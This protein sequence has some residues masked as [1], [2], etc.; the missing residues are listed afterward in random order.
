MA[1]TFSMD[2]LVW[3]RE[4]QH[5]RISA[6][7]WHNRGRS[8]L[9]CRLS[10]MVGLRDPPW[11]CQAPRNDR[12]SII[13]A[14]CWTGIA[15]SGVMPPMGYWEIVGWQARCWRLVVG[16]CSAV[17]RHR[18]RRLHCRFWRTAERIS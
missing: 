8:V 6:A 15:D 4:C 2:R 12:I 5:G 17:K 18:W 7:P 13:V 3:A 16:Y 9:R 10:S 11:H 14:L 1:I